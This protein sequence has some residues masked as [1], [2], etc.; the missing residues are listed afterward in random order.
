MRR[1]A[2]VALVILLSGCASLPSN[3][4]IEIGPELST[5]DQQELSFYSPA[6]PLPGA[7]PSEIVSG[8]LSAGTGPQND[9]QVAREYLT[10]GFASRWRPGE[11]TLI[12]VGAYDLQASSDSVQVVSVLVA[13]CQLRLAVHPVARGL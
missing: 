6:S 7:S 4:N 8:F 11:Q 13:Q 3:L 9:Y 10:D 2:V 12:R 1:I 5:P